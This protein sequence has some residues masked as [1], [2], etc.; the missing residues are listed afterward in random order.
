M[1]RVKPKEQGYVEKRDHVG[2]KSQ[3]EVVTKKK[4]ENTDSKPSYMLS[5]LNKIRSS[6]TTI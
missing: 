5:L 1:Y 3:G 2:G 6:S 4:V